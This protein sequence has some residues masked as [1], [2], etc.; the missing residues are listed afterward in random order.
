MDHEFFCR[1]YLEI[2]SFLS[3][4]PLKSHSEKSDF[5]AG[6]VERLFQLPEESVALQMSNLL[7]S[8]YVFLDATAKKLL[9]P[10]LLAPANGMVLKQGMKLL[11]ERFP[12]A[13]VHIPEPRPSFN[14]E[15]EINPVVSE[16]LF[17]EHIVPILRKIFHV[18][19]RHIR[20]VLLKYVIRSHCRF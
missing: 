2:A 7:L 12:E 15:Q 19:D 4:L 8:R 14:P 18:R 3:G 10:S 5:F 17:K 20:L 6:L 13:Y 9:L 16:H 1:D 11:G